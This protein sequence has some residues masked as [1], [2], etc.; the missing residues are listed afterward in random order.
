MRI[1]IAQIA[2]VVG[3]FEN[4]V[5]LISDAYSRACSETERARLLL[6]PELSVSGYALLDLLERPEIFT[7]T[8]AALENLPA[9]SAEPAFEIWRQRIQQA[10]VVQADPVHL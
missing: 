4:N 3:D 9:D 7:R 2:P 10:F 6:T 1:A 5:A 8:D